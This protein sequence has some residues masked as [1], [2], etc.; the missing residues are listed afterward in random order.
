MAKKTKYQTGGTDPIKR[1]LDPVIGGSGSNKP[2]PK[3]NT[4]KKL[5]KNIRLKN[6]D[7]ARSARK[8]KVLKNIL[9]TAGNKALGILGFMGAGTLSASAG[10]V[11]EK[12]EGEQI[13]DLLTKHDLKGK[14][15]KKGGK[16][17]RSGGF[18]DTFL[19]PGIES[20]D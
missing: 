2:K 6:I 19:E 13:R 11:A 16:K 5:K 18:K 8:S 17:Y 3:V 20:L 9:K 15:K 10:N 1:S 7:A 12:S 14:R 4:L